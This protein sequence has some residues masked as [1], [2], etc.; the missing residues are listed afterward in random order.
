MKTREKAKRKQRHQSQR[1]LSVV[2]LMIVVAGIAIVVLISVPGSTMLLEQYR[3][4]TAS[5]EL[6]DGLE[7]AKTEADLR[8]HMALMCP[9]SNGHSCRTD[10][11]WNHGW[12]VFSDGNGNGTVQDIELIRAFGAPN[13]NIRIVAK[14]AVETT[15]AFTLAGLVE[16]NGAQT[17]LFRICLKDSESPPR[18]VN[19]DAEGWVHLAPV[20]NEVCE[21]R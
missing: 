8:S 17:G 13:Q 16:E 1:G 15:A 14:G 6:L 5:N 9:S 2:E 10:G 3:L 18:V 20:H 21:M 4:K 11:N 12:L 19:V 7:L